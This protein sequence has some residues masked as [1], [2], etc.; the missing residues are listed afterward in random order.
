MEQKKKLWLL[1]L[2]SLFGGLILAIFLA[3]IALR[4]T[5]FEN[6]IF[7]S[8][9]KNR[10]FAREPGTRGWWRIEGEAY[11]RINSDGL[12]DEEHSKLKPENTLRIAVLGDSYAEALQLPIEKAFWKTMEHELNTCRCFGGKKVEVINF[13]VGGYGTAQEL[14]TL[15]EKVWVYS[16]DIVLLAFCP[17]NDIIDNSK[18]LN[19]RLDIPYFYYDNNILTL[20]DSF[21]H[22]LKFRIKL[23]PFGSV[24]MW[25]KNNSR[26]LQLINRTRIR[27]A[28][29]KIVY[30][31]FQDRDIRFDNMGF[32]EPEG[33]ETWNEA[34]R[35][36]EGLIVL[37]RDEVRAH[38]AG[39]LVVTLT[40]SK[41]VNP[42]P[43][44]RREF[45]ESL[46]IKD[47][48]YIDSRIKALGERNGFEVFNLAPSFQAYAEEN[49]IYLHGFNNA[50]PHGGH[51]NTDGHRL[52]GRLIAQKICEIF[53][54][55]K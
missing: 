10:G 2:L 27:I 30:W 46:K 24:L 11:I 14:I 12:R 7:Y 50:D 39:F 29:Q 16:P 3:E 17:E 45:M 47:L 6:Q 32:I 33:D 41:Q 18:A 36:T 51:W 26:V 4:I 21:K 44:I 49:K 28:Q 19:G 54:A 43:S 22:T 15:R 34:W 55:V 9:D 48:F 31:N 8:P 38:G 35:V 42:D 1:S 13:G 25:V 40:D 23:S 52:A 37:M 5:S 20:D 53:A